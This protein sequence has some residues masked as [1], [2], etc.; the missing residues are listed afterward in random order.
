VRF[1]YLLTYLLIVIAE[2]LDGGE[3]TETTRQFLLSWQANRDAI[4]QR[5]ESASR[6]QPSTE[7]SAGNI[8]KT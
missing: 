1:T 6:R 8:C 3:I 5:L 4:K 7:G 2:L